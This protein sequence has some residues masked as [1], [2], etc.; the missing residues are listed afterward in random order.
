MVNIATVKTDATTDENK[1]DRVS[2]LATE[3]NTV[4]E[5]NLQIDPKSTMNIE[6]TRNKSGPELN[7]EIKNSNGVD[8]SDT[9]NNVVELKSDNVQVE[10]VK[11]I[12]PKPD[13]VATFSKV[14]NEKSQMSEF[15]EKGDLI[16]FLR[17]NKQVAKLN[18]FSLLR[19][20]EKFV[21]EI[22]G[23]LLVQNEVRII[24][25]KNR[26]FQTPIIT[27]LVLL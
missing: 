7:E 4:T 16:R 18:I 3:N 17:V 6:S 20:Q 5:D 23:K 27:F 2:I 24:I 13:Y 9:K 12:R 19:N 1:T 15:F 26:K 8:N 25:I 21:S 10:E 14:W 11:Q 22:E